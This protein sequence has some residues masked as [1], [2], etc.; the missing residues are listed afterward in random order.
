MK[1]SNIKAIILQWFVPFAMLLVVIFVMLINFSVSSRQKELNEVESTLLGVTQAYAH[2]FQNQIIMLQK[3]SAPLATLMENYTFEDID[4]ATK[5]VAAVQESTEAYQSIIC[6]LQGEGLNQSGER[7]ELGDLDYFQQ[8][9]KQISPFVYSQDDGLTGKSSIIA[10]VP[11]LAGTEEKG[12]LLVYYD[13][14]EFVKIIKKME[15]DTAG[16]YGIIDEQG[17]VICSSGTG[18]ELFGETDFWNHI[19]ETTTNTQEIEQAYAKIHNSIP[20]TILLKGTEETK[21]LVYSPVGI[22]NWNMVIGLNQSYVE[23]LQNREWENTKLMIV[24]LIIAVV[25]FLSM[26]VVINIVVKVREVEKKKD[27]ENKA[28]T[29]LLTGL[30]NK[31]ATERKIKEYIATHHGEQGVLFVLDIDN[32]KKIND[33]MGHAFGDEVLRT[34]GAQIH[35]EIRV[36][37]I[38]GRTGGDEFMIFLKNVKDDILIEKEGRKM[39]RF[40]RNFKAGEYVKYSATASIGASVFPRDAKDFEGLY[41]AADKALY[42]AKKRGKNQLAFYGDGKDQE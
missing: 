3:A 23:A 7:V 4:I 30:N 29:D 2:K 20:G 22:N 38:V 12:Y 14:Q 6:N 25:V 36:T 18:S 1:D 35:A 8:I 15:F 42:V 34:L 41:K 19:L 31:V 33:T 9:V 32:F 10:M 37:D 26:L 11:I 13:T 40:F 27:L 39:E 17:R 16:Y 28:D 5:V 24:K 21:T